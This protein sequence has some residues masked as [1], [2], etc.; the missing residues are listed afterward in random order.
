MTYISPEEIDNEYINL[1]NGLLNTRTKELIPH[2]PEIYTT[3]RVPIIF[4]AEADCPIWKSLLD[5]KTDTEISA[6]L[7]E[8]FGYCYMPGQKYEKAF[9]L[10]GPRRTGKSTVLFIL[11]KMLGQENVSAYHLQYLAEN[12][13]AAAYLFGIPANICADLSPRSLKNVG[14]FM[15]I[16]GGDKISVA[17]K[18]QDPISF[19]PS[20][21]L[22]FSCNIIPTSTNRSLT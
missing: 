22:I 3:R 1:E 9:L 5:E 18:H 21:K 17:K 6:V 11:G 2:T 10:H 19:Y 14:T 15:T 7:Q 16:T 12:E 13:F 8:M 20:A 4:D